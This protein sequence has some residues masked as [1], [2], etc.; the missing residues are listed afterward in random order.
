MSKSVILAIL[1]LFLALKA[2]MGRKLNFF[3]SQNYLIVMYNNNYQFITKFQKNLLN[4]S[5]VFFLQNIALW[6]ILDRYALFLIISDHCWPFLLPWSAKNFVIK[7]SVNVTIVPSPILFY[8][9]LYK[10]SINS[11][12]SELNGGTK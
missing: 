12:C 4:G 10:I 7:K 5:I 2:L 1:W 3:R 8:I 11:V 9:F 6:A